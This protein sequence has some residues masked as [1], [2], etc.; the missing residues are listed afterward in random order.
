MNLINVAPPKSSSQGDHEIKGQEGKKHKHSTKR[1]VQSIFSFLKKKNSHRAHHPLREMKLSKQKEGCGG[2]PECHGPSSTSYLNDSKDIMVTSLSIHQYDVQRNDRVN[3]VCD[4]CI[5]GTL[6]GVEDADNHE[7]S[8][9]IRIMDDCTASTSTTCENESKHKERHVSFTALSI[10]EYDLILG[11]N[12]SCTEGPP[13]SLSWQHGDEFVLDINDYELVRKPRRTMAQLKMSSDLRRE[14]AWKGDKTCNKDIR[15]LERRLY[16]DRR[17]RKTNKFFS[18][19]I[20][21]GE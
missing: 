14:I 2:T 7:Y 4:N 6:P 20:D 5:G 17:Q 10:R 19:P 15:R 12:P 1:A 8:T 9:S 21:R 3:Q 16:K 13:L 18:P 11:D